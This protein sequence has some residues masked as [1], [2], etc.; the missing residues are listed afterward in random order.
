MT[1]TMDYE[2]QRLQNIKWDHTLGC[3]E[4]NTLT[5]RD[6]QALLLSLGLASPSS[7]PTKSHATSHKKLQIA[8]QKKRKLERGAYT[9][10]AEP[11]AEEEDVPL[12]RRKRPSLASAAVTEGGGGGGPLRRSLRSVKSIQRLGD[13]IDIKAEDESVDGDEEGVKVKRSRSIKGDHIPQRAAKSLGI[14]T[15]DPYVRSLLEVPC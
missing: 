5:I 14:R 12:S 9:P 1:D 13:E 15:Q 7:G 11:D 10:Q 3:F 8:A 6:N 4:D 2:A